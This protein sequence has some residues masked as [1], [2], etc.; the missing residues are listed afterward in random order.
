MERNAYDCADV[1]T[2]HSR[3]NGAFLAKQEKVSPEKPVTLHNWVEIGDS[4]TSRGSNGYRRRL[5][6]E[7][8]FVFFFGGVLGPSQGL[9]LLLDA[10][11]EIRDIPEVVILLVGDG[12]EKDRL[13]E[14]TQNEGLT[15]VVFHPFLAKEAYKRLLR[16]IDVG[17]V[18]LTSKNKT[19][20]VPG[21]IL[22]YMG[23][24]I[25]V[26]A[27]LNRES[28]GHGIVQEARCGYSEV[29]D[30]V[31]KAAHLMRKMVLD[32]DSLR[33]L[34]QN[35]YR[36]ALQNFSKKVCVDKLERYLC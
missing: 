20:V 36:Y 15:N 14:R 25:P 8:K 33:G 7:N 34:G 2:V 32:Q 16:E 3:S 6:L 26:L 13:E 5:G 29:S 24:G 21:K 31:K 10:A 27:F 18:S 30:S 11:K 4:D 9:D 22:G 19:P 28:D 17:L 1:V 12:T 23:A 35:G